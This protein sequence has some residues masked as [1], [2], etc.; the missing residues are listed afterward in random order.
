MKEQFRTKNLGVK[1]KDLLVKAISVV[2]EYESQD[3]I[4]T[5]R[6]LYYQLVARDVIP[7]DLK[8]Y[9]KLG[10]LIKDGRY[11]GLIDWIAIEDRGRIAER[12]SQF[13]NV[14][15]LVETAI[16]SYRLDRWKNQKFY[17]ELW[18]E[19]D[20]LTSVLKPISDTWHVFF[21]V[22]KGYSSAS[23][24]YEAGQRF[25][26]VEGKKRIVLYLGDH[27]PSGLDMVR[28]IQERLNEF[29]AEVVVVHIALTFNQVQEFNPPPNYAKLKDPRAKEYVNK[30]GEKSWEVDALNPKVMT[31]LVNNAIKKYVDLNEMKKIIE[32]EETE[33]E[34]LKDFAEDLK[35]ND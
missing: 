11:L 19:K 3:I 7:N 35:E 28:D 20:A 13:E 24:I 26:A 18:T 32:Q 22:N 14:A 33:K 31:E 23:A 30:F 25:R 8:S 16:N 27:D 6:Q 34:K 15:D 5:L 12:H 10:N 1:S 17:V 21:A 4:L 29:G 2:E 9:K